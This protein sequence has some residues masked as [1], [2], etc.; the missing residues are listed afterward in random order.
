M[1]VINEDDR[2]KSVAGKR[3]GVPTHTDHALELFHVALQSLLVVSLLA[4]AHEYVVVAILLR[5]RCS[6]LVQLVMH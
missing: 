5:Q 3:A 2:A 6:A 4:D 1:T